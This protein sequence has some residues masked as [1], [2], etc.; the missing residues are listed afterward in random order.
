M[1]AKII[2]TKR[3]VSSALTFERYVIVYKY[4]PYKKGYMSYRYDKDTNQWLSIQSYYYQ[5]LNKEEKMLDMIQ[6]LDDII[7]TEDEAKIWMLQ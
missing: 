5:G 4:K 2:Y 6:K 3:L 1:A 7:I